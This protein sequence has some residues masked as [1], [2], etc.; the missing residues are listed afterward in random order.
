MQKTSAPPRGLEPLRFGLEGRS[1]EEES[2]GVA[3]T[4]DASTENYD[5]SYDTAP[6]PTR[7]AANPAASAAALDEARNLARSVSA[8]ASSGA[9]GGRAA[10]QA[11]FAAAAAL[12]A[13]WAGLPGARP[14]PVCS[15]SFGLAGGFS[16]CSAC[17]RRATKGEVRRAR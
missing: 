2:E 8:R 14:A 4:C 13:P 5:G 6:L 12:G 16:T 3:N 11:A 9:G 7:R 1:T 10:A 17:G 15:H